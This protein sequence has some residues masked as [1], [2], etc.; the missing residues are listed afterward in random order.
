MLYADDIATICRGKCLRTL[1]DLTQTAIKIVEKWCKGVGLKVNPSKTELVVFT[2]KKDLKAYRPPSLFGAKL[3]CKNM[4]K[5]LG[6]TL[7]SNLNW[8]KHLEYRL[9]KCLRIFWCCKRAIGKSWG[10][11]PLQHPMDI[12]SDSKTHTQLWVFHMVE[13]NANSHRRQTTQPPTKG[14]LSGNYGR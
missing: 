11:T 13:G 10:L 12:Y 4:V 3:E 7:T 2:N 5:Y 14:S 8:N 9:A 6:I 1:C